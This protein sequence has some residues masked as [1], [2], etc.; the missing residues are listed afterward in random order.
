MASSDKDP[1]YSQLSPL[2]EALGRNL[3]DL[4]VLSSQSPAFF[5]PISLK[6]STWFAWVENPGGDGLLRKE[7]PAPFVEGELPQL[8]R[9]DVLDLGRTGEAHIDRVRCSGLDCHLKEPVQIKLQ[10]LWVDTEEWSEFST[11]T[12]S[13]EELGERQEETLLAII[14]MLAKFV[15]DGTQAGSSC[16]LGNYKEPHAERIAELVA[17]HTGAPRGLTV[18][19]VRQ[20]LTK[21]SKALAKRAPNV[22]KPR[23]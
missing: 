13:S 23:K 19:N 1:C 15:A 6:G 12:E 16:E 2:A 14:G 20:Y 18:S 10:E 5:V 3:R 11:T 22:K 8:K 7:V 21:A 4:V 9:D 17:D